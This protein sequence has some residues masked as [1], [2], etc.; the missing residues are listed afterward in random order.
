M[1][2]S[3][4][5]KMHDIMCWQRTVNKAGDTVEVQILDESDRGYY[6][7]WGDTVGMIPRQRTRN[8]LTRGEYVPARIDRIDRARNW[9]ELSTLDMEPLPV[10]TQHRHVYYR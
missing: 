8:P 3:G 1:D 2:V 4:R 10:R 6:V 5:R 7:K 9:Y